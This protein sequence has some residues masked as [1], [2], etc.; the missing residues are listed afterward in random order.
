M[1]EDTFEGRKDKWSACL[2]LGESILSRA[3]N[4]EWQASTEEQKEYCNRKAEQER[5]LATVADTPL[6]NYLESVSTQEPA[7]GPWQLCGASGRFA[8]H[9]SIVKEKMQEGR[10]K[11]IDA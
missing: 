1:G 10:M 9:P 11:K 8:V 4:E 2:Q 3:V 5:L 6:D 7:A